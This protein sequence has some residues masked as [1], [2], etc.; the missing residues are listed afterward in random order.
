MAPLV[1][2]LVRP[3]LGLREGVLPILFGAVF[4]AFPLPLNV[5]IDSVFVK[6]FKA[7]T[8]E[9]ML[10]APEKVT[11]QCVRLSDEVSQYLAMLPIVF[12][13]DQIQPATENSQRVLLQGALE[14]IYRW[15]HQ[16]P[17]CTMTTQHL[18]STA[19]RLRTTLLKATD[20]VVLV[21]KEIPLLFIHGSTDGEHQ[22]D[23]MTTEERKTVLKGLEQTVDELNRFKGRITNEIEKILRKHFAENSK[24]PKSLIEILRNWLAALA[25]DIKEYLDDPQCSGF[26]TRVNSNYETDE[27]MVESLASLVTGRSITYWDDS[28]IRQFEIGLLGIKKR[29]KDTDYLLTNRSGERGLRSPHEWTVKIERGGKPSAEW[30]VDELNSREDLLLVKS[31]VERLFEDPEQSLSRDERRRVLLELL[32]EEL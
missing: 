4:Q 11:V 24:E 12:G 10:I 23:L 29:I 8:F 9:R 14:S 26:V 19:L 1:R 17:S 5:M 20:P 25:G 30:V 7:E 18:S 31:R 27:T 32:K 16:L 15:I 22:P 6:D 13:R 28:F 21:L 3:P 2:S